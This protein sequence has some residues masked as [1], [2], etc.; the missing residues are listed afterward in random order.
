[1]APTEP[2]AS[3]PP[4]AAPASQSQ[5][6]A[7]HAAAAPGSVEAAASLLLGEALSASGGGAPGGDPAR[8]GGSHLGGDGAGL[9]GSGAGGGPGGGPGA[10]APPGFLF[11]D[12]PHLA[13]PAAPRG[14]G[15]YTGATARQRR[16]R[17]FSD[18]WER[19]VDAAW[20]A[21]IGT[22]GTAVTSAHTGIRKTLAT[23]QE[24]TQ[25]THSFVSNTREIM[26]ALQ[27]TGKITAELHGK[28]AALPPIEH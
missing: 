13:P 1:V 28:L 18:R 8:T 10:A 3:A 5:S 12:P 26:A 22:V 19:D 17:E 16:L 6:A 15:H 23:A 20:E 14:S 25:N 9:G 24:A 21:E 27:E 2:A 4:P 11:P 7:G